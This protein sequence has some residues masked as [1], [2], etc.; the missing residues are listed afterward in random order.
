MPNGLKYALQSVCI[1]SYVQRMSLQK[2]KLL[3][4]LWSVP[5]LQPLSINLCIRSCTAQNVK[6]FF[7]GG[8]TFSEVMA[9]TVK[10]AVISYKPSQAAMCISGATEGLYGEITTHNCKCQDFPLEFLSSY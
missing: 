6:T 3:L 2:T 4:M 9:W 10:T 5:Q 8:G 1:F 7:F